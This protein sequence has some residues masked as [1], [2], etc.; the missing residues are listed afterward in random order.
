MNDNADRFATLIRLWVKR[1]ITNRD[2][3]EMAGWVER[4]TEAMRLVFK[5]CTKGQF[6][7]T[8]AAAFMT[9]ALKQGADNEP[10]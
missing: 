2:F 9:A 6:N 10:A 3:I 4:K 7:R 8:V 1:K 5:Q